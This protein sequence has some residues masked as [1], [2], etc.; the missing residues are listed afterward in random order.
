[1]NIPPA[2]RTH[3]KLAEQ[4]H[5]RSNQPKPQRRYPERRTTTVR[6]CVIFF[7]FVLTT[8][9][10]RRLRMDAICCDADALFL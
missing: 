3:N 10:P 5:H 1:M 7:V 2:Q 9:S 6:C 4:S 8:L